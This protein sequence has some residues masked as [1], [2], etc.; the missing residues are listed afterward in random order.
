MPFLLDFHYSDT[1]AGPAHQ[2]QPAA[3]SHLDFASLEAIVT[4]YTAGV[5]T[6]L[7]SRR[8]LADIVR[9]RPGRPLLVS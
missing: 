3:W 4:R 7:A 6:E 1:W 9:A 8:T 5:I 2:T